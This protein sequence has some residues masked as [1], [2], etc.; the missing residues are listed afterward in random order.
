[1]SYGWQWQAIYASIKSQMHRGAP[2]KAVHCSM[3]HNLQG[4]LR[5]HVK[6]STMPIATTTRRCGIRR[7]PVVEAPALMLMSLPARS[8]TACYTSMYG[9]PD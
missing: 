9:L 6:P 1:M 8:A 2:Q 3:G 5:S 7:D 4:M